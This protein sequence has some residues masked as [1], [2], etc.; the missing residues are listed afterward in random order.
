MFL[1]FCKDFFLKRKLR[2]NYIQNPHFP[3][4]D[5]IKNIG[6]LIDETYFFEKE[7]LIKNLID[8][9]FLKNDIHILLF[10]NS[11]KKADQFLFPIFSNKDLNWNGSNNN[12]DVKNFTNQKFDLLINYYD[13]EKAALILVSAQSKASFKVGFS[14]IDIRLN[15]FIIQSNVENYK[16]FISE[17]LKY[18]KI[19][20]KI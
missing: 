13:A 16:I 17:L 6:I 14:S 19:L 9:G 7:N 4:S 15:Q 5:K 18:L 8:F 11:I 12:Q 3:T 10:R 2:N 1:D 20:K